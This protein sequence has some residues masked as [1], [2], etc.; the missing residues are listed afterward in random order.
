[1]TKGQFEKL[2]TDSKFAGIF[3]GVTLTGYDVS[4]KQDI[5]NIQS[6]FAQGHEDVQAVISG[7]SV[8]ANY[9]VGNAQLKDSGDSLELASG[10][11]MTL[12][13]ANAGDGAGKFVLR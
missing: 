13:N 9:S 6:N 12:V 4:G 11:N 10:G 2:V 7:N 5:S 8:N 3:D 1:M